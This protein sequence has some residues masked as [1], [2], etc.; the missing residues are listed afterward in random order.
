MNKDFNYGEY[1]AKNLLKHTLFKKKVLFVSDKPDIQS[2]DKSVGIEYTFAVS[3]EDASINNNVVN[4][5]SGKIP[6]SFLISYY[7]KKYNIPELKELL[8]NDNVDFGLDTPHKNADYV[9]TLEKTLSKQEPSALLQDIVKKKIKKI[10]KGNY[11]GFKQTDLFVRFDFRMHDYTKQEID[12]ALTL[13]KEEVTNNKKLNKR[14]FDNIYIYY[15]NKKD[16]EKNLNYNRTILQI[17]GKTFEEIGFTLI[18][19]NTFTKA[20]TEAFQDAINF[21]KTK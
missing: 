4:K 20:K 12:K 1:L 16:A 8:N 14:F 10:N 11:D 5:L 19:T 13:L 6:S 17:N 9:K 2:K 18:N 3:E 15:Y 21:A 7:H